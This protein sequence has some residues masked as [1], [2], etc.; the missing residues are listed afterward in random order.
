[1]SI[2]LCRRPSLC[3][4]ARLSLPSF[5]GV[6]NAKDDRIERRAQIKRQLAAVC[7][8]VFVCLYILLFN[9]C[10]LSVSVG[11]NMSPWIRT[12]LLGV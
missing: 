9:Q 5:V 8:R 11:S 7:V 10:I 3:T 1:V 12:V 4:V 2:Q 6:I